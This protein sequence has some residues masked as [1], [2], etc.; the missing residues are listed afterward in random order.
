MTAVSAGSRITASDIMTI[1]RAF[2]RLRPGALAGPR[3]TRDVV[4]PRQMAYYLVRKNTNLSIAQISARF[5]GR[6]HTT[7][8][9]GLRQVER[10]L[11][12]VPEV[13]RDYEQLQGQVDIARGCFVRCAHLRPFVSRRGQTSSWRFRNV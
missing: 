5:G 6:D 7:V 4:W 10:R 12:A 13:A 11:A 3:R 2:Y 1:V 8:L 9:H